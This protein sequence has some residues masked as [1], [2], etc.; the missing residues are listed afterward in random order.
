[1]KKVEF[2]RFYRNLKIKIVGCAKLQHLEWVE[3]KNE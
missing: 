1:M 3:A 2:Y